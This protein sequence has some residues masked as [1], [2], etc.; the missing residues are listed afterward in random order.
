MAVFSLV[1]LI[2][3]DEDG[4]KYSVSSDYVNENINY[5]VD[6]DDVKEE[7]NA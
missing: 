1:K 4:K 2:V 5:W 7:S 6:D 3:E